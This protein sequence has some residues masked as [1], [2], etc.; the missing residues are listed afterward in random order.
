MSNKIKKDLMYN[1]LSL[2]VLGSSGVLIN[3]IIGK[4]AGVEV[5][6]VF[7]QLFTL[8][9][10][11]SQFTVLGVQFSLLKY[12]SQ[13]KAENK[14][15]DELI[16]GAFIAALVCSLIV[17]APIGLF[18]SQIAQIFNS[19]AV[20]E[21]IY[22]LLPAIFL[23]GINKVF[24][25]VLNGC[26]KMV[27]FGV[28]QALR[29]VFI[30]IGVSL[31]TA[32]EMAVKWIVFPLLLSEMLMTLI[33]LLSVLKCFDFR[34]NVHAIKWVK[35][36]VY[37]GF[38]GVL[39]GGVSELNSRID[40]LVIGVFLSDTA[41]GIYTMASTVVEGM[42]QIPAII[43]NVI[44]PILSEYWFSKSKIDFKGFVQSVITKTYIAFVAVGIL[45]IAA[46]MTLVYGLLGHE[47]IDSVPI[48]IILTCGLILSSG[49]MPLDM[50]LIQLGYPI[51]QSSYKGVVMLINILL[52]IVFIQSYGLAG[53][54]MATA[55]SFVS[56][57]L[58][59]SYILTA[60]ILP[61]HPSIS[62]LESER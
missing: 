47:F 35:I 23:F 13:F 3:I 34:I 56:G 12:L 37:Y 22:Y 33:L 50:L 18:A 25:N 60:I 44:N 16:T 10:I 1:Y 46:Y 32:L 54:A 15:I 59:L 51:F 24:I 62:S 57:S 7:N 52:N 61:K 48:F 14:P 38:K 5:L 27:S 55:I 30:L 8:Y 43:R 42:M 36:H 4:F 21:N 20:L 17:I 28:C 49:L 58:L 2:L 6:G 19:E 39:N 11:V 41:V 45:S 53:V 40:V 26:R 29:M 31:I 9:L